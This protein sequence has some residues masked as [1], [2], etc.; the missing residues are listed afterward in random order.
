[1]TN[2]EIPP[3]PGMF[4]SAKERDATV[5]D[6]M[7]DADP[8]GPLDPDLDEDRQTSA[9]ADARAAAEGVADGDVPNE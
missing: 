6:E 5:D 2:P 4:G 8:D 3:P 9:D 7:L 1:M